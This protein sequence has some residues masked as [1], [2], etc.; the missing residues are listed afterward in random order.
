MI[1]GDAV[2][3]GTPALPA[4]ATMARSGT[5]SA[6]EGGERNRRRGLT[7]P[8]LTGIVSRSGP[9]NR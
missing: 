7:R 8:A 5:A 6:P 4:P 2:A 1:A 3:S 9:A